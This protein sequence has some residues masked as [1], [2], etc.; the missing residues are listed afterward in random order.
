MLL[1]QPVTSDP[2]MWT[3]HGPTEGSM[4]AVLQSETQTGLGRRQEWLGTEPQPKA[5]PGSSCSLVPGHLGQQSKL[6]P[7]SGVQ[8]SLG[9]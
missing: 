8:A 9:R 7:H 2:M 3:V 4:A 6:Q 5:Q 1:L